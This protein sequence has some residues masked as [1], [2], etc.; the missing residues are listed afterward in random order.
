MRTFA[1]VINGNFLAHVFN[2]PQGKKLK[3]DNYQINVSRLV[4]VYIFPI[5]LLVKIGKG[6]REGENDTLTMA[7]HLTAM[8][9]LC[10]VHVDLP[11]YISFHHASAP[12]NP[13]ATHS[14]CLSLLF[15]LHYY[16]VY[17]R[18]QIVIFTGLPP[19]KM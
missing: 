8:H 9:L 17:S 4:T 7:G 18:V 12:L 13:C 10:S 6:G 3:R 5:C 19:I 1:G 11:L 16:T 14:L 15:P 2:L